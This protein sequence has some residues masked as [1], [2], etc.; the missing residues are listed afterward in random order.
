[1]KMAAK[2]K[3]KASQMEAE[4]L[5]MLTAALAGADVSAL[6]PLLEGVFGTNIN[7]PASPASST[8]VPKA[9]PDEL[10]V[11]TTE[12]EEAM[13]EAPLAKKIKEE[14]STSKVEPK[15]IVI[16]PSITIPTDVGIPTNQLP[17]RVITNNGKGVYPC[18]NSGCDY[19]GHTKHATTN[20]LRKD[21]LNIGL[22][23]LLCPGYYAF[24]AKPRHA[25]MK[26]SHSMPASF[27]APISAEEAEQVVSQ[28]SGTTAPK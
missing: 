12:Q 20:H 28:L 10:P 17:K 7:V 23:C 26:R 4:A 8:S 16:P 22:G 5:G 15:E 1:M 21:H 3:T 25:H 2:L 19:L 6:W 27:L 13:E 24:G 14:P 9:V 18:T 11:L